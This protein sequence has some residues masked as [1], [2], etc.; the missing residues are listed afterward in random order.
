MQHKQLD[1]WL[2][3]RDLL[4]ML[5]TCSQQWAGVGC[6]CPKVVCTV[7]SL[8]LLQRGGLGG[9]KPV[10]ECSL[11]VLIPLQGKLQFWSGF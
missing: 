1:V 11:P 3:E 7:Y 10:V 5:R 9:V 6:E 2:C 4:C 8:S